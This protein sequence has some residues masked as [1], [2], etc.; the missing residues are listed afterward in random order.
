MFNFFRNLFNRKKPYPRTV[1]MEY[2]PRIKPEDETPPPLPHYDVTDILLELRKKSAITGK[3]YR[4]GATFP[5]APD[6][7]FLFGTFRMLVNKLNRAI[8][9]ESISEK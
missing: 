7:K 2:R 5:E 6:E 9:N 4:V 1:Q 8:D 3:T